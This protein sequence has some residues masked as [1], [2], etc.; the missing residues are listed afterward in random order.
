MGLEVISSP[1]PI[2]HWQLT[3]PA[4]DP[5]GNTGEPAQEL[6][7]SPFPRLKVVEWLSGPVDAAS[8]VGGE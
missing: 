5:P 3:L 4:I 7:D 8:N 2:R 6:I 1:L